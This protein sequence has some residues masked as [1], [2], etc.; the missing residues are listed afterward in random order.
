MYQKDSDKC[1]DA[2][3][4]MGV[5]VGGDRTSV[6]RTAD[7]FLEARAPPLLLVV[8]FHAWSCSR[9]ERARGNVTGCAWR[10][11]LQSRTLMLSLEQGLAAFI[12]AS[13]HVLP[14]RSS[15]QPDPAAATM[16]FQGLRGGRHQTH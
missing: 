8:R 14:K 16:N 11:Q 1:L 13:T 5:L 7:F 3:E 15:T 4:T 2:L 10:G 6:K 9:R 12:E